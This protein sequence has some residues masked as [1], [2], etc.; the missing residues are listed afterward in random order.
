MNKLIE[1][2][3]NLDISLYRRSL[4]QKHQYSE[5]SDNDSKVTRQDNPHYWLQQNILQITHF[6]YNFF[7]NLT[8]NDDTI[9][10]IQIF[11]KFLLKFFRFNYQLIWVQQDES[12]YTNFPQTFDK[13]DLLPFI[14]RDDFKHPRY[15]NP[16]Q[17][18][19]PNFEII[20]FDNDFIV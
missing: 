13:V 15:I 2:N 12:A 19:I 3:T 1:L 6:Q 11:A 7:R 4:L 10:Q 14:K 9:P 17:L 20:A 16:L 18:H 8:L 5:V